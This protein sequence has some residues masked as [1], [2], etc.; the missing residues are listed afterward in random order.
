[1]VQLANTLLQNLI[2]KYLCLKKIENTLYIVFK[3]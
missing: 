1:M 3:L 2:L